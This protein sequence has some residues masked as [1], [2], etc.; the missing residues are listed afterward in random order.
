[1]ISEVSRRHRLVTL[2]RRPTPQTGLAPPSAYA[3]SSAR[4]LPNEDWT[5]QPLSG[6]RV[7]TNASS[8]FSKCF[9]G[10]RVDANRNHRQTP[11][12]LGSMT[13]RPILVKLTGQLAHSVARYSNA[14][15]PIGS[16]ETQAVE[17]GIEAARID[18]ARLIAKECERGGGTSCARPGSHWKPPSTDLAGENCGGSLG[19]RTLELRLE[20]CMHPLNPLLEAHLCPPAKGMDSA[21]VQ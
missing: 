5:S 11:E 19:V 18:L 7:R 12:I 21:H 8:G 10:L 16:G 15:V 6:A 13:R 17:D 1:M 14:G 2:N 4:P 9:R 3:N 20:E